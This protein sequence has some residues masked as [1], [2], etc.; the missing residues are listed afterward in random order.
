MTAGSSAPRA[1]RG[2]AFSHH[3]AVKEAAPGLPR[4]LSGLSFAY[5]AT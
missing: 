4:T 3:K 2:W 5:K 1:R